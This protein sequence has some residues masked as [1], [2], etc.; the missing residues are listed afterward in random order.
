MIN[1]RKPNEIV[2]VALSSK[3][4]S[5][6][7]LYSKQANETLTINIL[8]IGGRYRCGL[9]HFYLVRDLQEFDN[10]T[11]GLSNL[12]ID[13]NF[14]LFNN[15]TYLYLDDGVYN[16]AIGNEIGL[17]TLGNINRTFTTYNNIEQNIVYNG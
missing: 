15:V 6:M 9:Y 2:E 17:F 4:A 12:L 7:S 8:D 3:N 5:L 13:N 11:N 14:I 1:V 16:Y 10:I